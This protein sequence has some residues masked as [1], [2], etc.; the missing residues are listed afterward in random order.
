MNEHKNNV[1]RQYYNAYTKDLA[2]GEKGIVNIES[3]R[4][5]LS[6][7]QF[8]N[9][10][11]S[12]YNSKKQGVS[13]NEKQQE[14]K[15]KGQQSVL[16]EELNDEKPFDADKY[17]NEI[18]SRMMHEK[19]TIKPNVDI[20]KEIEQIELTSDSIA[21]IKKGNPMTHEEAD[22]G[23]VNPLYNTYSEQYTR[24]CQTCAF[25]YALRRMG[26][27]IEAKGLGNRNSE[28]LE[29]Q[30]KIGCTWLGSIKKTYYNNFESGF[31]HMDNSG[32]F[33]GKIITCKDTPDIGERYE[34]LNAKTN[35]GELYYVTII[36]KYRSSHAII[37]EKIN[38]KL[39]FY[40]PQI[41]KRYETDE[42]INEL[43]SDIKTRISDRYWMPGHEPVTPIT[44]DRID[45][46]KP[47][48]ELAN[49]VCKE[50]TKRG[51]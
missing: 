39:T 31:C 4:N 2:K 30:T 50:P 22:T 47:N 26:R 34:D 44:L 18:V 12:Y 32:H 5:V 36:W 33:I 24:N 45:N 17:I 21:G 49:I 42:D 38:G 23:K 8:T 25:V 15:P 20:K 6:Q 40:D 19:V 9:M 29:A 10:I 51:Q 27:D 48:L 37:A 14:N 1:P 11:I 43:F 13:I 35:D 16:F 3:K 7:E 46:L 41:N 28:L